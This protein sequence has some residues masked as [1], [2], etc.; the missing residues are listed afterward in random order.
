MPLPKKKVESNN[1][2]ATTYTDGEPCIVMAVY[3]QGA[4]VYIRH[5]VTMDEMRALPYKEDVYCVCINATGTKVF[6]GTES[7]L[8]YR[9][10]IGF[11]GHPLR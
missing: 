4:G 10:G 7:G 11:E 9:V 6:F 3:G 2:F 1:A 8:F 5:A